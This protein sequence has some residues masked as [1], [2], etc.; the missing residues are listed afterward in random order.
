MKLFKAYLCFID[1]IAHHHFSVLQLL[2]TPTDSDLSFT[3]TE[4]ARRYIRQLPRHSRQ[5]LAKVFPHV[6]PLAM[7]LV[8]KMLTINPTKRIT[9]EEALAHPYLAKLH[10]TA[11]EPVCMEP[12]SFDLEHQML[13]EE[14]MKDMIYKEALDLNPAYM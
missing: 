2:G 13:T 4:D 1:L 6:N 3:R 11:D 12:F 9:V 8:D 10:D 14:Q 7:D 5:N